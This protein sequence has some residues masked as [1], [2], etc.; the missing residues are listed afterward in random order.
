MPRDL[1]SEATQSAGECTVASNLEKPLTDCPSNLKEAIDWILRVTNKDGGNSGGS[2]KSQDL[3]RAITELPDF[4][5]AIRSA[6]DKL[7]ESGN[8]GVNASKALGNLKEPRTLGEIIKKLAEGLGAFIGYKE[9][10]NGII[11]ANKGIGRSTDPCERLRDAVLKF[12][13]TYFT[14]FKVYNTFLNLK[15]KTRSLDNVI[16]KLSS[17]I[18]GGQN[19]FD[20][21]VQGLDT[22]LSGVNSPEIKKVLT[23]LQESKSLSGKKDISAL[24]SAVEPYLKAVLDEV[25]KDKTVTQSAQSA[26]I[27]VKQLQSKLTTLVEELKK[28][29]GPIDD[30]DSSQVMRKIKSFNDT[31]GPLGQ[32]IDRK[33]L[34]VE[35]HP[36]ARALLVSSYN[37][38]SNF[39]S[40]LQLFYKSSY[41]GAPAAEFSNATSPEAIKYAKIFLA[42]LPLIFSNLQQLY[43]KCKQEK[44]QGGWK[45]MLLNGSAGKGADLKHFMDLMTFSSVRLNGTMT[46]DNVVSKAF[47]NFNEFSTAANGS[48]TSYAQFLTK[49]RSGCLTT[50]QS[51]STTAANDNFL[52]GLYLC[53]TSY[54]SHQHKKKAANARPPSSIREMLYWLMGL[55]ATP[56]FG[57]LL[58]HIDKVVG[59]NFH[60]A[61]SGSSTQNETLSADQVTSYILSTCYTSPSVLNTI[62]GSLAFKTLQDEP[63]LYDLYSNS[64]FPFKYPS[65]AALFY[66]LSDYTYALQFQLTFLYKQ[67]EDMYINTCGWQFCTFGKDINSDLQSQIVESHICVIGCTTSTGEHSRGD[68]GQGYCKHEGCGTGSKHSPLQAFLTD[69]LK[70]FSRGHPSDPSSHLATCSGSLCHV[71]MG[72][73]AEYLL[74]THRGNTQGGHISLALKSFCGS[75]NTPLRQLCEMLGCLTKRTPRSLGDLFGFMWHLNGQL[76][77][78]ERP[79]MADLATKLVNAIGQNNPSKIIPQFFF[80]LLEKIGG[81]ASGNG[82]P[83]VLSR[84]VSAMAPSIPFLYQ[85]FM[86]RDTESLP[87]ALFDLNQ[88]CHKVEAK[89]GGKVSVTHNVNGFSHHNHDCS[90]SPAD[91]FSLQTS[92]CT[93]G[94]NC[95]PYLSPLTMS[96]GSAF[97]PKHAS[98]YLS[99]VLYLADDLA[100][101]LQ[102]MVERFKELNCTCKAVGCHSIYGN[103]TATGTCKSVVECNAVLPLLYDNGFNF[104]NAILLKGMKLTQRGNI[105]SYKQ[106][107]KTIRS[108][109]HF[110]SQFQSVIFGTPLNKFVESTDTVLYAIRWEFFSKLSTFWTIYTCLILYTFFFL[111]DTLHLRS[112]LKFN[113]SHMVPPLSLLTHGTPL[114]VT[115]LTYIT[116]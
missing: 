113:L 26:T 97:A 93:T 9:G 111:L 22:E 108:C 110:R 49:F 2:D 5:V 4:E 38:T 40:Q 72:F 14:G 63:W 54:F 27:H 21:A 25:A 28:H 96:D 100:R 33:K 75:S 67:C 85:L 10:I 3:A 103:H 99:W 53:S 116:Q 71:P 109:A 11:E 76:C 98:S 57:D 89:G 102:E 66:A 78:N 104:S 55:T 83:T 69:R 32:A 12:T 29:V 95:G 62:Q 20:S 60:V 48:T 34:P 114:P 43:W 107:N 47:Q 19:K 58:G 23:Q 52:S 7:K 59:T 82:S 90:T 42:C 80:D 13:E 86:A 79:K 50:W 81:T 41:Q 92:R 15:N 94:P 37:A 6:A 36:V 45:E 51:S 30:S 105:K 39:L 70:G 77:K 18:E 68:H 112:H 61:V 74:S 31:L 1:C 106:E 35:K 16:E 73:K 64:A 24:A 46:G 115:K 88:Q 17:G 8:V 84:S 56:Q 91:L 44:N 101:R 87:G 65:G